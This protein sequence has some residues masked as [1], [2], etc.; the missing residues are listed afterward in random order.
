MTFEVRG[1]TR[2]GPVQLLL[3]GEL[4]HDVC[5]LG[6]IIMAMCSRMFNIASSCKYIHEQQ[7]FPGELS[8]PFMVQWW[9]AGGIK[10]G[11]PCYTVVVGS[12]S[13]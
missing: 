1:E 9:T 4:D 7:Q 5:G 10:Y 6:F 12:Y 3:Q 11:S 8:L 2:K 13:C